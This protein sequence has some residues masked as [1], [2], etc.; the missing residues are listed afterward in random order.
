M[1]KE[2]IIGLALL[3]AG[4]GVYT[5]DS[6][7][8]WPEAEGYL[9]AAVNFVMLGNYR[10]ESRDEGERTVNPLL[11]QSFD[12]DVSFSNDR[13]QMY[14]DMEKRALVLPK[15][16]SI[17]VFTKCKR[18]CIPMS[19]GDEALQEYYCGFSDQIKYYPEGQKLWFWNMPPLVE[20]V[21]VR[22]MVQVN[23]IADTDE[24]LL[25]SDGDAKVLELMVGWLTGEKQKPDDTIV[26]GKDN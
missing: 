26:D 6:S 23:D 9:V 25:P 12:M 3:E 7:A 5:T 11:M 16:R 14:G 2:E 17:Q 4:G 18:I 13:K 21:R 24:V 22:M 19:Q 8:R 15:A 1:T 10:L 20:G